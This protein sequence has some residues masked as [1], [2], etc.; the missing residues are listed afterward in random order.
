M[1]LIKSKFC[2]RLVECV[3]YIYLLGLLSFSIQFW[4][5]DF[6]SKYLKRIFSKFDLWRRRGEGSESVEKDPGDEAPWLASGPHKAGVA[7]SEYI[8]R[9]IFRERDCLCKTP[10]DGLENTNTFLTQ[11]I[12]F[13]TVKH[14]Q[15][16]LQTHYN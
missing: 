11:F 14:Y 5:I 1:G 12:I 8:Y 2:P 10:E 16:Q 4:C 13:L 3:W 9:Y 6:L 15:L 7:V